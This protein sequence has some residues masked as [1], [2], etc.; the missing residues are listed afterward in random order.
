MDKDLEKRV[1]EI[2]K[3]VNQVKGGRRLF[4]WI[5]SAV[6]AALG[7]LAAFWERLFGGGG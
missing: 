6:G 4:L 1:R 5:C 3:F 2:E 7:L